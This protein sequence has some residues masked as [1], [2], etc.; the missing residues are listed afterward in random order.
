VA[1]PLDTGTPAPLGPNFYFRANVFH[2]GVD[3]ANI[4]ETL[5]FTFTRFVQKFCVISIHNLALDN[6]ASLQF[7]KNQSSPD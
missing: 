3:A 6:L 1:A 2:A 7:N 5:T 4:R